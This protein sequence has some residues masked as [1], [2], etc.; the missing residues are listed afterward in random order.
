MARFDANMQTPG[1]FRDMF[2]LLTAQRQVDDTTAVQRLLIEI[3]ARIA[4]PG[5]LPSMP[6]D[7]I[8]TLEG[9]LILAYR[10]VQATADT[11]RTSRQIGEALL[12]QTLALDPAR[13]AW[14]RDHSSDEQ[15][16]TLTG[17]A[18][19]LADATLS[20]LGKLVAGHPTVCASAAASAASWDPGD[21]E[22]AW[23]DGWCEPDRWVGD[24]CEPDRW[25]EGDCYDI[26]ISEA[27][28]GGR[29]EDWG[30]YDYYCY[31]ADDCRYRWVERWEYIE[32]NCDGGYYEERC[33]SGYWE[34]GLCYDGTFVPGYCE[35]GYYEYRFPGGV[36]SFSPGIGSPPECNTVR[37]GQLSIAATG[38]GVLHDK[39]YDDLE[40]QWQA[41]L[42]QLMAT[43]K[44]EQP[45]ESAL[46]A[47]EQILN[48]VV[49]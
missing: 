13:A 5:L 7:D 40:T 26:W 11:P 27:C 29:W 39:A 4:E 44:L 8:A 16:N 30:Y 25:L 38:A 17:G 34:I 2:R 35:Q 31:D 19:A 1:Y 18:M 49:Q 28:S 23:V 24:Y 46:A 41:A 6:D 10:S 12:Y 37:P 14:N 32:G 33:D 9:L 43:G 36:W 21:A 15:V 20:S 45:D 22:M 3:P 42:D 47:I 48:A